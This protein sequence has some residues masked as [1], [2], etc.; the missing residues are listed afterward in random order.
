MIDFRAFAD[1]LVKISVAK[2]PAGL[3]HPAAIGA[4]L[5]AAGGALAPGEGSRLEG[6]LRGAAA[7]GAIGV[8]VK[9]LPKAIRSSESLKALHPYAG[10][11]GWMAPSLVAVPAVMK[12]TKTKQSQAGSI[13]L[14]HRLPQDADAALESIKRRIDKSERAILGH[15]NIAVPIKRLGELEQ[16]GFKRTRLAVPLPGERIGTPSWRKDELHAHRVG[17]H[18]LMHKDAIPPQRGPL[19]AVKHWLKEGLPATRERLREREASVVGGLG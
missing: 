4:G 5:G 13:P 11:I 12:G 2:I 8:G 19:T 6:A 10:D 14:I 15:P 7:G 17:E 1:E 16:Y 18:Y 9:Y 3:L